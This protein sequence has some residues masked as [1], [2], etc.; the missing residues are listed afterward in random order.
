MSGKPV[1]FDQ[2]SAAVI[3]DTV[4]V[5]KRFPKDT[6][7][8]PVQRVFPDNSFWAKITGSTEVEGIWLHAW[9]EQRRTE[10][11]FEDMPDPPARTGT[12]SVWPAITTHGNKIEDDTFV[13]LVLDTLSDGETE[14]I[15]ATALTNPL[16]VLQCGADVSP[17]SPYVANKIDFTKPLLVVATG[18]GYLVTLATKTIDVVVGVTCNNDGTID[19]DTEQITV[20]DEGETCEA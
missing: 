17:D 12:T 1:L 19:I 18:T 4:R 11:T 8:T 10:D 7:G 20:I 3:A 6:T 2:S 9:A 13:R 14:I 15:V 5:V 16:G